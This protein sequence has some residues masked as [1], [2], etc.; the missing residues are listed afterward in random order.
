MT[1]PWTLSS[2]VS[3]YAEPGA[4]ST[5][6][7]WESR[8]NFNNNSIQT[9]GT[10]KHVARSPKYDIKNKT[11]Y[12]KATGFSFINLPTVLSGI[13]LKLISSRNGR[14]VDETIQL[15]IDDQAIGDNRATL[16]ILPEKIYGGQEDLWNTTQLNIVNIQDSS[17]GVIIRLQSHP[18]WPHNDPAAIDRVELRIH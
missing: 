2:T 6:I 8:S 5:H 1:T 14:I 11:Y 12:L 7:P 4:E 15:C 13:E 17:F 3:Q 9:L 10:L 16:S 18:N